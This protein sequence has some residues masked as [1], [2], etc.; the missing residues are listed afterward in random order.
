MKADESCLLSKAHSSFFTRRNWF[1][2]YKLET[3]Q[4]NTLKREEAPSSCFEFAKRKR[5]CER[6]FV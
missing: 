2:N 4:R 5:M 3:F 6:F 1:Q